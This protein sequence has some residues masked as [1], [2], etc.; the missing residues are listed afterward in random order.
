[1][2]QTVESLICYSVLDL[3][4]IH[5]VVLGLRRYFRVVYG[6]LTS[7]FTVF[8]WFWAVV[9]FSFGRIQS[10]WVFDIKTEFLHSGVVFTRTMGH[11]RSYRVVTVLPCDFLCRLRIWGIFSSLSDELISIPTTQ[12][13]WVV[14]GLFGS[15]TDLLG[16]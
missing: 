1:M 7:S 15:W 9:W 4:S 3:V 16:R 14:G 11:K 10:F 6:R 12:S 5:I 13:F 2:L 8:E